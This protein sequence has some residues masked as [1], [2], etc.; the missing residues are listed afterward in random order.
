[1]TSSAEAAQARYALAHSQLGATDPGYY[2]LQQMALMMQ[3]AENGAQYT[4]YTW[5][6]NTRGVGFRLM[7]VTF[8]VEFSSEPIFTYGAAMVSVSARDYMPLGHGLVQ[9][10]LRGKDGRSYVGA[11]VAL[12][13]ELRYVPGYYLKGFTQTAGSSQPVPTLAHHLTFT[14]PA[15]PP[16][17]T[18]TNTAAPRQTG[19]SK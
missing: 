16:T 7:K 13:V 19:L 1:M 8:D 18:P 3:A 5:V 12:L 2:Q 10:W 6:Q 4:S 9:Q 15:G 11:N 17:G 14:A